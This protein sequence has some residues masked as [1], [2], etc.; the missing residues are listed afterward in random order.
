M[1]SEDGAHENK[2]SERH[3]PQPLMP[4]ASART[5]LGALSGL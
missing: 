3:A 2:K 1:E 4:L 5:F